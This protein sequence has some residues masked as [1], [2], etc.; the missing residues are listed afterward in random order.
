M[1]AGGAPG[2]GPDSDI[3]VPAAP[4]AGLRALCTPTTLAGGVTELAWVGAHLL[5]YPL[6]TRTPAWRPDP[7]I[8]PGVQ[9]PAARAL[10]AGDPLAAR[11]PVVLVHGLV[12]NRSVFSVMQRSLRLL[13]APTR[14]AS[15]DSLTG[16]GNRRALIA[17]LE[18]ASGRRLAEDVPRFLARCTDDAQHAIAGDEHRAGRIAERHLCRREF[19]ARC[20]EQHAAQPWLAVAALEPAEEALEIEGGAESG[21]EQRLPDQ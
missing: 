21:G 8:R 20:G 7:R 14:D 4:R 1:R 6:G 15:T 5:M 3:A 9:P 13:D 2:G 17:D 10:F 11:I 19:S 12:D 16:L 18:V